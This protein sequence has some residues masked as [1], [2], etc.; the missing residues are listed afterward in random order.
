V[1]VCAA[2]SSC[3]GCERAPRKSVL[4][5]FLF[6]SADSDSLTQPLAMI[7]AAFFPFPTT[8][9]DRRGVF[10]TYRSSSS[11]REGRRRLPTPPSSRPGR[12]RLRINLA[13]S[14]LS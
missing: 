3:S 7:L 4:Q 13:G 11:V 5:F 12:C 2:Y 6:S 10:N 9:T 14:C 8:T 1:G